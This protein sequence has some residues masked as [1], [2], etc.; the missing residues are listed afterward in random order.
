MFDENPGGETIIMQGE[1]ADQEFH[2]LS[3]VQPASQM[4]WCPSKWEPCPEKSTSW[5]ENKQKQLESIELKCV[6]F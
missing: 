3:P 4:D 6:V 1:K 5:L 2:R